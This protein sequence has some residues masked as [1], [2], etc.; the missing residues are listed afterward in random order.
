MESDA[1]PELPTPLYLDPKQCKNSKTKNAPVAIL[2][3]YSIQH[4]SIV[5][6]NVQNITPPLIKSLAQNVKKLDLLNSLK[7]LLH[8]TVKIANAGQN[9]QRN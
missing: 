4:K 9:V 6:T 7:N 1:P 3:N 8:D 5:L 2:S